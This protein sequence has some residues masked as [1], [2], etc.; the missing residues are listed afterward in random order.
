MLTNLEKD[1]KKV[2]K[3]FNKFHGAEIQANI[4]S[5]NEN[6]I[7]ME[8]EGPFC[9]TCGVD[10]YFEDFRLLLEEKMDISATISEIVN[11][12]DERFEVKYTTIN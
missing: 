8:F 4:I 12:S 5:V 3:E 1:I 10:D 9:Y 11:V 7:L 2:I 6:S